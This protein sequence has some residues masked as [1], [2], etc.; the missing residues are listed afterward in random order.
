MRDDY[1]ITTP[2]SELKA[3]V[4]VEVAKVIVEMSKYSKHSESELIN[5][6]LKRFIASHKD[7][8]PPNFGSK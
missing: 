3:H 7:F 8:L 5:T 6:A 1:K 4:E 2:T